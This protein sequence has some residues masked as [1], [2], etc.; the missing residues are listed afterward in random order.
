MF[1][2]LIV[3]FTYNFRDYGIKSIDNKATVLAKTIEHALTTQMKTGV[4]DQREIFLERLEDLPTINNIWLSRS[5]KVIDMYGKGHN[6]E[7]AKDSIDREVLR[8]GIE[9]K[10]ISEKMFSSSTYRITIPYKATSSG[11]IN[12]MQCHTNAK[13]GDTLGAIT[14]TIPVD[15]S[16]Q[17]GITILIHTTIIT[18]FLVLFIGFL[19]NYLISPFLKLFDSI[20][21]VMSKAQKGDYSYRV[22]EVN[23][24][25]ARDVTL[26]VNTLLEKL[27]VTL[28]NIDSRISIFLTNEKREEKDPL[29]NVKNT[30]D[31]LANV[32][33]FRKTIEHD[34]NLED[35]YKRLASMLKINLEINN[36]NFIEA[37]TVTGK[38]ENV[39]LS[40]EEFC[41]T[42]NH[43]CRADKTNTIIDSAD[44]KDVCK[45]CSTNDLNYI[46]IPHAI[47]NDIDLIV[48][49]YTK[50]QEESIKVRKKIP[51]IN[52]YVDAAKT[53][54]ISNKLMNI[55]EK[56]ARTDALTQLYNRKHLEEQI[57]KITSQSNRVGT[58]FGVLMLDIDHFK[59]VNDTYGHD[60]GDN[61]I[62]IVA[63]TLIENTRTSDIVIRYGGEEFIVLLYNCEEEY[64]Y[65]VCEKIRK[66][67]LEKEISAGQ[68]TINKTVSIGASIFPKDNKDLNTCI[69]YA[70]LA[71]YKAKKT[72]RNKVVLFTDDLKPKEPD[73]II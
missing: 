46:C 10:V 31:R 9:K 32:Y 13:D 7:I 57:P 3:N 62:K 33:K 51:Y 65:E 17:T 21:K 68:T 14:I 43:P 12:C 35:I 20:K 49:I 38:L 34:E 26:W 28:G 27:E 73:Y 4:I 55:L 42:K 44:F 8:T 64:L 66:A 37:D 69:K 61:A 50:D 45:A 59:M 40:N 11:P 48:A 29:I 72:G 36:F 47:S 23:N 54:I 52:D 2:F 53:V 58:S 71:L 60:V 25:D 18:L 63:Q 19:I 67:F 16:K 15:D 5:Q 39:Y 56:N 41:D 6:N 70:D 30:V 1:V 24:K 22:K